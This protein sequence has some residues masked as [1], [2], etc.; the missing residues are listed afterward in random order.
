LLIEQAS[1]LDNPQTGERVSLC[2]VMERV[3]GQ[4]QEA[5]ARSRFLAQNPAARRYAGFGDFSLWRFRVDRAH[6]VGGFARATWI[7]DR[8][9]A[10]SSLVADLAAIT[11]GVIAHMNSD[12]ADAVAHYATVLLHLPS[13]GTETWQMVALDCDGLHLGCADH[14]RSYYLP[15]DTPLIAATDC[16]STLVALA[17]KARGLAVQM[18]FE[19]S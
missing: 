9:L 8:L 19:R 15:F 14:E 4:D 2:G 5:T 17:E 16:R 3:S 11:P 1:G 10:D 7:T 13:Q 6:Y 18:T 12:H